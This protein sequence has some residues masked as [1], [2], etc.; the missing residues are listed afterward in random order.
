MLKQWEK[1]ALPPKF[2]RI[3]ISEKYR[4]KTDMQFICIITACQLSVCKVSAGLP[5]NYA[6]SHAGL[7]FKRRISHLFKNFE[8]FV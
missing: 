1:Q 6:V 4:E 5:A 3:Q 7:R 8:T 2:D